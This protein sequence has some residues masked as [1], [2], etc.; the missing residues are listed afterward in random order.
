MSW[1][2]DA[3]CFPVPSSSRPIGASRTLTMSAVILVALAATAAAGAAVL[4]AGH[5]RAGRR[6]PRWAISITAPPVSALYPGGPPVS[7]IFTITSNRDG[8]TLHRVV[9][10]VDA[11]GETGDIETDS[12][13]VVPGCQ[14]GWFTVTPA[15]GSP[16][17]P[18]HLRAVGQTYRGRIELALTDLSVDQDACERGTPAVTVAAS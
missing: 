2:Q 16:P 8:A 14:A 17:P 12:G 10:A 9:A 15:P 13:L 6:S 3:P 5:P 1:R 11:D 18:I 7:V 4:G